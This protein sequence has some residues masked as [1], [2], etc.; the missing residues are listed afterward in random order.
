MRSSWEDA[1]VSSGTTTE[2]SLRYRLSRMLENFVTAR[3]DHVVVICEGLKRELIGRGIAAD[4]ITVVPNALPEE[5]FDVPT[6]DQVAAIRKRYG[7]ER[8]RV[9]GFFGSFFEWEGIDLLIAALPAVLAAVPEARLL[10]AGGG[11]QETKLRALVEQL[12]LRDHV[13]FAGRIPHDEVRAFYGAADVVAY[14]RVPDRLTEIVTPL[15]P[16]EAMAQGTPVVA[17]DVGG[18]REL[19]T[20]GKTGFLFAAGDTAALGEKLLEVLGA[21]P[22]L[23]RVV[24]AARDMVERERRWSVVV[25]RYLP[26]YA[27]LGAHS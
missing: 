18:H 4:K 5:M 23:D 24:A 14:P 21:G 25:E 11:R 13:I 8:A 9:I 22:A 6:P 26:V 19:L 1:A 20:D 10:L 7:L 15:K 3:A 12:G 2:G 17:S 16:L 27:R